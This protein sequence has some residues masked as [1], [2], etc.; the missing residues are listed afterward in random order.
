VVE[1]DLSCLTVVGLAVDSESQL[2][3]FL[4][5]VGPPLPAMTPALSFGSWQRL[6]RACLFLAAHS[7]DQSTAVGAPAPLWGLD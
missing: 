1:A 3:G 2:A 6:L 4:T 7:V 5:N